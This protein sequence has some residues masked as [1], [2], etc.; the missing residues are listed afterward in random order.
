MTTEFPKW[1]EVYF[2]SEPERAL[3]VVCEGFTEPFFAFSEDRM[4]DVYTATGK[5][6]CLVQNL[7]DDRETEGEA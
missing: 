7:I 5:P 6:F 1:S 3:G 4:E 2:A